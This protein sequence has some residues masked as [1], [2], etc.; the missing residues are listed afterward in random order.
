[1]KQPLV[2][3]SEITREHYP[4]YYDFAYTTDKIANL[5]REKTGHTY[6]IYTYEE[7]IGMSDIILT[8]LIESDTPEMEVIAPIHEHDPQKQIIDKMGRKQFKYLKKI[9]FSIF[10]DLM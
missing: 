4:H 9:M 2:R 7:T 5:L 1:M 6:V 10:L 8:Q 3:F